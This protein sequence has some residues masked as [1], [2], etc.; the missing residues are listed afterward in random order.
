MIAFFGMGL[1][2]SNF[3][4]ALRR[5]GET[6]HVWNRTADKARLLVDDG[7]KAFDDP[8]LAAR[9]AT[10]VHLT[11]SDDA[12][13]D[14]V[15]ERA[16]PGIDRSATIID[17]TTTSPPGTAARMRRWTEQGIGFLHAPVFMGPQNALQ[18]S[19]FMVV[20]GDR[21]RYDALAHELT[22]MTGKLIYAG[23]DPARAAAIKLLGNS[24]LMSL[25]VGLRDMF[26][27]AKAFGVPPAES[28]KIFDW[29]NP[30][31]TVGARAKRMLEGDFQHPSWE[32]GMARKDARL[33]LE[34]AERQG[35]ELALLPALAAEMDRWIAKGYGKDD[36]TVIAHDVIG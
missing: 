3:V 30:A 20:S 6:V 1:L 28:A 36:W 26:A 14:E 32:L 9:G 5:H 17:H 15:L 12:S 31:A 19:G 11:L 35:L 29:F 18:G 33:M 22:K 4:R 10:R 34:E 23:P 13:V 8:A 7:A 24:F 27:L 25:T 16:R 21:S 2:G